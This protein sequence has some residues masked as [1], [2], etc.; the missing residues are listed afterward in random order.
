MNAPYLKEPRAGHGRDFNL[1]AERWDVVRNQVIPAIADWSIHVRHSRSTAENAL[2]EH[3]DFRNKL[4]NAANMSQTRH[5]LHDVQRQARLAFME[6]AELKVAR[7]VAQFEAQLDN[8]L[9]A[10]VAKPAIRV[11]AVQAVFVSNMS[12]DE[13]CRRSCQHCLSP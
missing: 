9:F 12:L 4:Q 7:E 1:S 13:S 8:A 10:G 11:D 6:T 5:R 2:R 3:D